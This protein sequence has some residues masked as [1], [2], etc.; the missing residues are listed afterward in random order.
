MCGLLNG[1]EV[2]GDVEPFFRQ[3]EQQKESHQ[4]RGW[5]YTAEIMSIEIFGDVATA[6]ISESGYMGR[7][8]FHDAFH[9]MKTGGKW[10]ITSKLVWEEPS[11]PLLALLPP[12]SDADAAD[13]VTRSADPAP[14]TL[15]LS[16]HVKVTDGLCERLLERGSGL[17]AEVTK[18]LTTTQD[19]QAAARVELYAGERPFCEGNRFLGMMEL[20]PLPIPSY[21]SFVQLELSLR[22]DEGGAI[23]A[24]AAEVERR[25]L[26][27]PFCEAEWQG[28]ATALVGAP[29]PANPYSEVTPFS[30]ALTKH[31]PVLLPTRTVRL[32]GRD[33]VIRQHQRREEERIGTGGVLWEAAIVLADYKVLELGAGTGLVA[34]ALALEGA[35]VCATDGNPRVLEG[36]N[37][38]VQGALG[39]SSSM[40]SLEVFDWNSAND[41]A[42]FRAKGPWDVILGSDLVYPGN[43]GKKCVDS[44]ALAPP[45]DETLI[46]LLDALSD[47]KTE[48]I[49]A[50]KDRTGELERFHRRISQ[51]GWSMQR[52]AQESIMPEF[53]RVLYTTV[54]RKH[55]LKGAGA[56]SLRGL[57]FFPRLLL[58]RAVRRS[59]RPDRP[60][61]GYVRTNKAIVAARSSEALREVLKSLEKDQRPLNGVNL[62]TIFFKAAKHPEEVYSPST[63][64]FLAKTLACDAVKLDARQC[65]SCLYGLQKLTPSD[66]HVLQLVDALATKIR[67]NLEIKD[68]LNAQA[69]SNMLY[70]LQGLSTNFQE[71]R[72]LLVALAT[73]CSR[74]QRLSAQGV[75][76]ALYGL[77][78]MKSDVSELQELLVVLKPLI[79]NAAGLDGQAIGN[80]LYGLQSMTSSCREVQELLQALAQKVKHFDGT[81]TEQETS[82]ALYGL[83]FMNGDEAPSVKEILQVLSRQTGPGGQASIGR[84]FRSGKRLSRHP[85]NPLETSRAALPAD[86]LKAAFGSDSTGKASPGSCYFLDLGCDMGGFARAVA[87]ARPDLRVIGL[88]LRHNAV[89]FANAR[90]RA[91]G[92]AN[93]AFLESNAAQDLGQLLVDLRKAQGHVATVSMNFPDPHLDRV[94]HRERRL[95]SGK[96]VAWLAE[97]LEPKRG[98]VLFQSD[99]ELLTA[100]AKAAFSFS[101]C[102]EVLAW[103]ERAE[104]VPTERETVVLKRGLAVPMKLVSAMLC[105]KDPPLANDFHHP[106]LVNYLQ[107]TLLEVV[108]PVHAPQNDLSSESKPRQ[109]PRPNF[110]WEA[111][112]QGRPGRVRP[113][114]RTVRGSSAEW[115][116]A[117]ACLD[118]Q[119]SS[120]QG[121]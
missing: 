72:R 77:Q 48:I 75:G 78:G 2:A 29:P 54:T 70:G 17:P 28:E 12:P 9:L 88:E 41:L 19:D 44:N 46:G 103:E 39:Q 60:P 64:G 30:F 73:V 80:A 117:A 76:N 113:V 23:S 114:N 13:P 20:A 11:A 100:E 87:Q 26:G 4:S 107:N 69:V 33:V 1:K 45:A 106:G 108:L 10:K 21:R 58:L 97:H 79:Q 18:L 115:P 74:K 65:A 95:V 51:E 43:A 83:Q 53:R 31:L 5:K 98:E 63:L 55:S 38:N 67:K 99:V 7:L 25:A 57:R 27:E 71:V 111:Y 34:I 119:T 15:K 49:L 6:R 121:G 52:A 90:A 82:N 68:Q 16:L 101:Q 96:L 93:V 3:M 91:E 8:N 102:F 14:P 94:E 37:V 50:L 118:M 62:A 116:S 24:R 89:A 47:P 66:P 32:N 112:K 110:C 40:V 84:A 81:L 36:A 35:L 109:Y 59:A 120:C 61:T 42:Q 104:L 22:V 105:R 86:W 85:V 92:L 56:F